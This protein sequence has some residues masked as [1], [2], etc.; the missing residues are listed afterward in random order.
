[1]TTFNTIPRLT[2]GEPD[3]PDRKQGILDFARGQRVGG[4]KLVEGDGVIASLRRFLSVAVA[5][6][7]PLVD[8]LR[9]LARDEAAMIATYEAQLADVPAPTYQAR[10]LVASTFD[11]QR[12]ELDAQLRAKMAPLVDGAQRQATA[13]YKKWS[14]DLRECRDINASATQIAQAGVVIAQVSQPKLRFETLIEIAWNAVLNFDTFTAVA[15]RPT[16]DLWR[17]DERYQSMVGSNAIGDSSVDPLAEILR[18]IDLIRTT[19]ENHAARIVR[20][21]VPRLMA[22]IDVVQSTITSPPYGWL[23]RADFTGSINEQ[24]RP[25]GRLVVT[26]ELDPVSGDPPA[27]VLDDPDQQFTEP[28]FPVIY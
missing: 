8:Q 13:L 26:P 20:A 21:V 2:I 12:Q 15:I 18:A 23:G 9:Q 28:P 17:S 19:A 3:E 6:T 24:R 10:R 27:R 4:E 25:D 22:D 1:M 16:L 7:Q 11:P 5:T 14:L